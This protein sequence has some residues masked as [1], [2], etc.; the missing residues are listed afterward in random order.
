[1]KNI[2]Y[3]MLLASSVSALRYIDP[4]YPGHRTPKFKTQ[5]LIKEPLAMPDVVP[6]EWL[7]NN[8][9]GTN[10]LT[11]MYNQHIP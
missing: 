10:F 4:D 9:D 3:G 8:I 1:M 6:D 11:N 2:A 5:S 7:W